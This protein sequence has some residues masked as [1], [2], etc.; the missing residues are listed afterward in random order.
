[1]GFKE[2]QEFQNLCREHIHLI[3]SR[4]DLIFHLSATH[5]IDRHTL[6]H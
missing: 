1:M 6:L 2:I 3:L 4:K 5:N